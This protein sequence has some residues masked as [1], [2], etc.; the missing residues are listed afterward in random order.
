LKHIICLILIASC[1]PLNARLPAINLGLTNILD[2]GPLR[3]KKGFYWQEFLQGYQSSEL[4]DACG[5]ELPVSPTI[6]RWGLASQL[7]YQF[8]PQKFL[9]NASPGIG[10]SL[11]V[12]LASTISCNRLGLTDS[13]AGL[14]DLR[15]GVYA[16]WP[17]LFHKDR[18]LFVHRLAFDAGFPTGKYRPTLSNNPGNG[19][20]L[21]NPHWAATFFY[22]RHCAS[23]WRIHYLWCAK[24]PKTCYQDGQAI[25]LN[26]DL[27]FQ[28]R[29]KFWLGAVGYF[30]QQITDDTRNGISVPDTKQRVLGIGP[31]ALYFAPHEF[32][33]FT[34]FYFE[35]LSRNYPQGMRFVFRFLKHF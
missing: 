17:M 27:S 24:D 25:F 14:G 23:S 3:P 30:L 4:F 16:Q 12:A 33:I 18:P 21:V 13:G 10:F 31:G 28:L 20:F 8:E 9:A 2:G 19:F 34:Y 6:N 26:F 32:Y 7:F 1:C 29:Q 35:A 15:L 11:P 22:T 5:N